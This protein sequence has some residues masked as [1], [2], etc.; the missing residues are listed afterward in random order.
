MSHP[1]L[2]AG[3]PNPILRAAE[4]LRAAGWTP[5]GEPDRL[6]RAAEVFALVGLSRT[7][8][9]EAIAESRFPKPVQLGPRAVAW[10][11][12]DVQ[13]FIAG[14]PAATMQP[15]PAVRRRRAEA[16]AASAGAA[17]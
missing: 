2:P 10:R 15:P 1:L 8:V 12:S 3:E 14:L 9:Y 11:L 16:A 6:L 17:A 4:A 7:A 5:A 13:A